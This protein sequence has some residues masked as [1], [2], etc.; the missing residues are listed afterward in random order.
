ILILAIKPK[1]YESVIAEIKTA[2]K[3]ETVVISVAPNFTIKELETLL[4][5]H[6]KIV[7]GMPNTP[8]LVS[9]G[10]SSLCFHESLTRKE[11]EEV[12]DIFKS[13]S[14][15]EIVTEDMMEAASSLAGCGPAYVY[16]MIESMTD[17]GVSL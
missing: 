7:R 6:E 8:A 11:R 5:G 17:A 12:L 10:M 3:P 13:F 1:L 16:M 2:I 9:E 14:E 15:V 4:D